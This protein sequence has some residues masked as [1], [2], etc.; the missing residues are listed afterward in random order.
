[1]PRTLAIASHPSAVAVLVAVIATSVALLVST[2]ARIRDWPLTVVAVIVALAGAR[3][4]AWL[5]GATLGVV[6]AAFA[7]GVCANGYARLRQRPAALMLIPGL[8]VLVPGA[9]GL[10]GVSEFLR[11]AAGGVNVLV[12]VVIIAAG[13]VVG[14]L[15]AD[16]LLPARGPDALDEEAASGGDP[17]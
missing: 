15:V 17:V 11:S 12:S 9:L 1:M 6:V 13:L 7:L 4:G 3:F 5:F 2:N 14:L 10:R 16:A 8:G